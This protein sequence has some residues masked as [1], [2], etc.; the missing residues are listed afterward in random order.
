MRCFSRFL[1]SKLSKWSESHSVVSDSLLPHGIYSTCNSLG[2]NTG[3]GSLSLLQEVSPTQGLNPGLPHCRWILYQL[4]H[5][6]SPRIL[7]WVA[8]R[9]SSWPRNWTRV[10]CA[11]GG[12]FTNWGIREAHH[13]LLAISIILLAISV[14]LCWVKPPLLP[15]QLSSS[16]HNCDLLTSSGDI[17]PYLRDLGPP[18]LIIMSPALWHSPMSALVYR[19]EPPMHFWVS[20]LHITPAYSCCLSEGCVHRPASEH[21]PLLGLL[22]INFSMY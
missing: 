8:Y 5:R 4:G 20:L 3:V 10:S 2:Q 11:A 16:Y 21:H 14:I 12:F 7:E 1:G 15:F 17:P 19:G 9:G 6:G 13:T 18:S 22:C